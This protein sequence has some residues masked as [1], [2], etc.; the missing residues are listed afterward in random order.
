MSA[1]DKRIRGGTPSMIAP[2]PLQWDSPNV[3][4]R[5]TWPNVDIVLECCLGRSREWQLLH[6]TRQA[7][8]CVVAWRLARVAGRS[9]VSKPA[10]IKV[11]SW[12]T[13]SRSIFGP[14]V[15]RTSLMSSEHALARDEPSSPKLTMKEAK[16]LM[17]KM[18]SPD[19]KLKDALAEIT[20]QMSSLRVA[21]P[22]KAES[23][24]TG[25]AWDPRCLKHRCKG[26]AFE[27][28][29]RVERLVAVLNDTGLYGRLT[30]VDQRLATDAELCSEG[31]GYGVHT[32]KHLDQVNATAS[33]DYSGE[34]QAHYLDKEND[35]Y[36]NEHSSVAARAAAGG[37][38][39]LT[40]AI[41]SGEL[42]NGFAA[43][44][45]PGHHAFCCQ[46]SGFCLYNNA[47]SAVRYAQKHFPDK[48]RRVLLVDWDVHHGDGTQEIFESDPSVCFVSIHRHGGGFYPQSGKASEVGKGDGKGFTI[49]IPLNGAG[50]GD[51]HYEQLVQR[52]VVPIA[53]QYEPDLVVVSAGFD[54]ALGD[55]IG[56]MRVTPRGFGALTRALMSKQVQKDGRVLMVLEGGYNVE[57]VALSSMSC[58]KALLGDAPE[59]V[60]AEYKK[61]IDMEKSRKEVDFAEVC[62]I[63]SLR[64]VKQ[65]TQ[66]YNGFQPRRSGRVR[67][68]L[69]ESFRRSLKISSSESDQSEAK[70]SMS[71][72]NAIPKAK[73]EA[74]S[75]LS[76][77]AQGASAALEPNIPMRDVFKPN[78]LKSITRL[79][80]ASPLDVLRGFGRAITQRYAK[81]GVNTIKDLAELKEESN[82]TNDL[83]SLKTLR[84]HKKK[85]VAAIRAM[86]QPRTG[87]SG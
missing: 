18:A 30:R 70:G 43:I 15:G 86:T 59:P 61:E 1:S 26:E 71:G 57:A 42:R 14:A 50:F 46:Q 47:A 9:V 39:E 38:L 8:A 53:R 72:P 32:R 2:T 17:S 6:G 16:A 76:G 44:R 65:W 31:G 82:S 11:S 79:N 74:K 37:V 33:F 20:S 84:T 77:G 83:P 52:Y 4:T 81:G 24:S 21:S 12:D 64:H 67:V 55:P 23:G 63:V 13:C 85:A 62:R 40:K 69:S 56:G 41:L 51:W 66:I 58:I 5:R 78:A 22:A 45:P 60:T 10:K 29:E 80:P 73:R 35:T 48:A 75:T 36:V 34:S 54:C 25:L 28:P 19:S 7:R 68:Q 3:V 27:R 49:N 87:V